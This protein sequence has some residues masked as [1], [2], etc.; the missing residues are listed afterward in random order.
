MVH[1]GIATLAGTLM[2]CF[3]LLATWE[4][5]YYL[6]HFYQAIAYLAIILLLFYFEDHWAYAL[7]MQMP[8]VWIALMFG[9]VDQGYFDEQYLRNEELLEWVGRIKCIP[10]EEANQRDSEIN[11]CDLDVILRSGERKSVRI[12][13]HRGHWKNPMSDGEIEKKFRSLV[14]DMLPTTRVNALLEQLWRLEEL[15]EV[16]TLLRMTEA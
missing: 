6:L 3:F 14:A 11:L 16:G 8:L 5:Q 10:S 4:P 1:R 13:Y 9:T 2:V 7:G 15:T 12:E